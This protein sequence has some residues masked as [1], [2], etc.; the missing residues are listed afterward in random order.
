MI[1][2][3]PRSTRTDTLF[4]YTTLFRSISVGAT[5]TQKGDYPTLEQAVAALPVIAPDD[6]V[7]V[8]ICLLPGDHDLDEPVVVSRRRVRILGCGPESRLRVG[9]GPGIVIEAEEDTQ[10]EARSVGKAGCSK[11]RSRG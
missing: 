4:P 2:R 10:S 1:R 8:T 3:P 9:R 7:Y 11:G 5:E 6:E